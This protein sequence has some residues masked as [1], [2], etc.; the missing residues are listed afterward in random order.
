MAERGYASGLRPTSSAS[1]PI[2]KD[3]VDRAA[4]VPDIVRQSADTPG[5]L[6]DSATWEYMQPRFGH[7]F[8]RVRVR[9]HPDESASASACGVPEVCMSCE[10]QRWPGSAGGHHDH[11]CPCACSISSSSRLRPALRLADSARP[12]VGLQGRRVARAAARGR[13]AASRQFPA[14]ARLGRPGGPRR[15]DPAPAGKAADA[16]L[17]TPGT[18]LRWHRRLVTRKWTYPNRNRTA[19]G[20]RRNCRADRTAR[21]REQRLGYQRTQGELLKL[22]HRVGA[23][24]VRRVLKALKIPGTATAHRHDLA[25]VPAHPGIDDARH[26]LLPRGLR[27][28][29]APRLRLLRDRSRHPIRPRPGRD[30]ATRTVPGPCSRHGGIART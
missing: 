2:A 7:D 22:G 4:V 28:H 29:L 18:V 6:L 14:P 9:V 30:R 15:A 26:R 21:H 24:T 20:Q 27:G 13:R 1:A 10:L 3:D 25:E 11:P 16:P 5:R 19:A 17:V 23:S 8:S 12:V